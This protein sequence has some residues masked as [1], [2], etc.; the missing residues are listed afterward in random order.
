MAWT[1]SVQK[2]I[3]NGNKVLRL[4]YTDGSRTLVDLQ[5]IQGGLDLAAI[6][7]LAARKI[8]YLTAQDLAAATIPDG[9]LDPTTLKVPPPPPPP[10]PPP[11]PDLALEAWLQTWRRLQKA[12]QLVDIGV[13]SATLPAFV[14]LLGQVKSGFQF[15]YVDYI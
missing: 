1:V 8:D 4:T 14:A 9:V 13:I 6:E 2:A 5:D 7:V 11:D 15:S 12:Q 10:P 3:S